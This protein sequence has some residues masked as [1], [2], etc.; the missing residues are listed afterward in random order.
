MIHLPISS[1]RWKRWNNRCVILK[2][3]MIVKRAEVDWPFIM[4]M[5]RVI[6]LIAVFTMLSGCGSQYHLKRA[7]AKDP[8]ILA[9]T[10]VRFDTTIVTDQRTLVDTLVI[11]DTIMR[12]I[13]RNGVKVRLQIIHDTI[14]FDVECPPDTIRVVQDV[15]VERLIYKEKKGEGVILQ[16]TRLL[17][18]LVLLVSIII[19]YKVLK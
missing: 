18:V 1:T 17:G 8:T 19:G 12:E 11:R 16:L 2:I 15:P 6:L 9:D 4:A 3:K 7:I 10:I 14:R 5:I 13:V